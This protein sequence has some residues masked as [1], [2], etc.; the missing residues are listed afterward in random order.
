MKLFSKFQIPDTSDSL[1]RPLNSKVNC[2]MTTQQS[3]VFIQ[4]ACKLR[5]PICEFF[6][7]HPKHASEKRYQCITGYKENF[8]ISPLELMARCSYDIHHPVGSAHVVLH[9]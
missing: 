1:I 9:L 5:E 7:N 8:Q 6:S 4:W 2:V 3:L